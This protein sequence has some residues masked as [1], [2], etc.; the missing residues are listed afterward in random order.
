MPR[1]NC[2]VVT[3]VVWG[4]I[5]RTVANIMGIL[6]SIVG[7]IIRNFDRFMLN[8]NRLNYFNIIV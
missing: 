4:V 2:R 8:F 3:C 1:L 5:V 7:D 6:T